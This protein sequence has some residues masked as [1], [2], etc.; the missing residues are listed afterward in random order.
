MYQDRRKIIRYA[1]IGFVGVGF[2]GYIVTY[3]AST[4]TVAVTAKNITGYTVDE[5]DKTGKKMSAAKKSFRIKKDKA[6]T[7][8]Y[9][10]ASGYADGVVPIDTSTKSVTINPDYSAEKLNQMLVSEMSA[11]TTAILASGTSIDALYTINQG[12]LSHFGEWYFTT[13]TYKGSSEDASSDTLVVG[14]QKKNGAWQATLPPDIV[15]TTAAYPD[16]PR[17]FIN[18]AN[19]YQNARVTPVEESYYQ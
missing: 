19:A 15:F 12:S 10:G 4:R 1:I 14:L 7:L 8:N 11:L 16:A 13:L 17:D 2:I 18:A 6:Y 5:E 9:T 3:F